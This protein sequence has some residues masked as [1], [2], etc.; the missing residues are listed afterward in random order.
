MVARKILVVVESPAKAK[1]IQRILGSDYEVKASRGHL[2]DLPEHSLGV[3]VEAGFVP[4]YEVKK[5][6]KQVVKELVAAAKESSATLVATD[7]DREGEAIGWHLARLLDIDPAE[8]VRI[9]F[10]EITPEVVRQTIHDAHSFDRNLFEAQQARRVLDRLV[11]YNL[12]PL[13]SEHFKRRA[14]SAGRVQSVGLILLVEREEEIT[15]FQPQEYWTIRGD[16]SAEADF[17]AELWSVGGN[18][19]IQREQGKFLLQS[20][21]QVETLLADLARASYSVDSR[22]VKERKKKPQPPFTTSTLQQ[23]A[24]AAFGWA[25]SRTMRVAQRLYEGIDLP[26]GRVGLITYMRTDSFRVS[27]TAINEA[28]GWISSQLGPDYLPPKP[29]H[30]S[31]KGSNVQDAHEAIRPTAVNRVPESVERFLDEDER[32]LYGLIWRRFLASQINP[33]VFEQTILS[34]KGQ[35]YLFRASAQVLRFDGYLRVY[36]PGDEEVDSS[37]PNLTPG[38][39]VSLEHLEPV[40]H[41]TEPPPRYN[42]ATLVKRLEEIGV[43]RPST[44]APTIET[45]GARKY[46][47]RIGKA[48]KPTSLGQE[49]AGF[50]RQHF[51]RVVAYDFTARMEDR[52]DQVEQ[53]RAPW[54]EVVQ[55]FF[56]PFMEEYRQVPHKT[57]PECGRPLLVKIGRWGQFLGCSGYPECRYTEQL[58]KEATPEPTGE[59]CPQCGRPLVVRVG[60]Y[61]PFIACSGYPECNY[62]RDASPTTGKTCPL[63]HQGEI[64]I[65]RSRRGRTYYRCDHPG[66]EFF[67]FDP[68]V[69]ETCPECGSFLAE[70]KGKRYCPN[71]GCSQYPAEMFQ[72]RSKPA[73]SKAPQR[74]SAKARSARSRAP[75]AAKPKAAWSDLARFMPELGI[76]DQSQKLLRL[77][78]EEGVS[79]EAAAQQVGLDPGLAAKIH[80]REMF[81]LRMAYGRN[82]KAGAA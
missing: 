28:R 25:A 79:L 11:G 42:D 76:P 59:N 70:R 27:E 50:L 44:Y 19:V 71:R 9:H 6:K 74:S 10:H 43:G 47:E 34:V 57:C 20:Q 33:A 62:T 72:A 61:G 65:K 30:Y 12:S 16:F 36:N 48:L 53:G 24:S 14:L 67:S 54:P 1:T 3:D 80:K 63:C 37:L 39:P 15:K 56:A 31:K 13:L 49:V 35:D 18:K 69:D 60:R 41:F 38:Q 55:E 5:D 82:R 77:V 73:A 29:Q 46:L 23:G 68:L 26:D 40:Q 32:K 45:L 52:L 7:P 4:S 64:R 58:A 8:P 81:R 17:S 21:A 78:E 51:P 2:V 75:A 66:C 22:E